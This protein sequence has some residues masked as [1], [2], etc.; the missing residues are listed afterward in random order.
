[1]YNNLI[2]HRIKSCL[3]EFILRNIALHEKKEND[4][5]L[6]YFQKGMA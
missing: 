6:I 5:L 1:M 3:H 4:T 2:F